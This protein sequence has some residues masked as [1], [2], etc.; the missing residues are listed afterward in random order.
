M[1]YLILYVLSAWGGFWF[2]AAKPEP[3]VTEPALPDSPPAEMFR[4]PFGPSE[5]VFDPKAP[6]LPPGYEW[7]SCPLSVRGE[8]VWPETEI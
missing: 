6:K 7:K 1:K 3:E 4:I 8:C 2:W 5:D